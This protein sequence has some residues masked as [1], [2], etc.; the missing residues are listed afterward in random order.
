MFDPL[1]VSWGY[2]ADQPSASQFLDYHQMQGTRDFSAFL[3]VPAA[4]RFMEENDW[5]SV[6]ASCRKLVRSNAPRFCELLKTKPLAP[7]TDDFIG[8]MI[9]IPVKL[10]DPEA[11]QQ[12]LFNQYQI[13]VPIMQQDGKQYM[14]YSI[15]GFNSQDD[16]DQ[17]YEALTN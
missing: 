3:T 4:I 11:L 12:K 9:S 17:L 8:Q 1:V 2:N 15:N 13:E 14:R 16:L 7:L 6:A 10:S 5:V